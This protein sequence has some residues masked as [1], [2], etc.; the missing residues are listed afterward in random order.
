MLA[1][2]D[3]F[4]YEK[5][6]GVV[7]PYIITRQMERSDCCGTKACVMVRLNNENSSILL[8]CNHHFNKHK[9]ALFEQSTYIRDETLSLA[10]NRL[11]GSEK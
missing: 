4:H 6:D 11:V 10:P 3:T 8:F 5:V 1:E 2:P 7:L 9:D